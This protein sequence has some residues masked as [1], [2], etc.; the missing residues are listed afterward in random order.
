M[1]NSETKSSLLGEILS[2]NTD[3]MLMLSATPL[4]LGTDDLFNQLRILASDDFPEFT[5]FQ[6][7][8]E[9]NQYVNAAIRQL[10]EPKRAAISLRLVENTSQ[11]DRFVNNP[12]YSECLSVLERKSSLTVS[13]AVRI[14]RQLTEL[15]TLSHI[16]T[17]TRRRDI[18]TDIHFAKREAHVI[19]VEFSPEEMDVYKAVT[20]WVESRYRYSQLGIAFARIMPQ[21]QVSS[22]MPVMKAY[23]ED[24]SH[25]FGSGTDANSS[26]ATGKM[27][28]SRSI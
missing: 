21:R 16:F 1:K 3:A 10:S 27:D 28:A 8:I 11:R 25:K 2:E 20:D 24:R 23:V 26:G 13:E 7:L 9:P 6:D 5:F 12:N 15:N 14:Q 22:C 19:D 17:R 18:V 4:H